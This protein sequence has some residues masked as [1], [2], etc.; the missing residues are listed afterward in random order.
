MVNLGQTNRLGKAAFFHRPPQ[1]IDLKVMFGVNVSMF[2]CSGAVCMCMHIHY[3]FCV[4]EHP[5]QSCKVMH[6]SAHVS[7]TVLTAELQLPS[8]V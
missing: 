2:V 3:A 4:Q 5:L 6:I 1:A 8:P 7:N